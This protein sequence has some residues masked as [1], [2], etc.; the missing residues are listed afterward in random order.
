ME[1]GSEPGA[2]EMGAPASRS[3]KSA[4]ESAEKPAIICGWP[5]RCKPRAKSAA[6]LALQTGSMRSLSEKSLIQPVVAVVIDTNV[7]LDWLLFDDPAARPIATARAAGR[8]QWLACPSMRGEFLRVV[9]RADMAPRRNVDPA[10]LV[11]LWD[12]AVCLRPD[13]PQ[14]RHAHL[15]CADGDDQA[16]IDLAVAEQARWLFTRDKALLQLAG[17]A[18][19]TSNLLV[20]QPSAF[21]GT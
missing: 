12:A 11:A 13:P 6:R 1:A 8:L 16:F 21:N 7:A 9:H 5:W 18:L 10:A 3:T 15:T 2:H 14:G 4:A 17:R 20:V 19:A